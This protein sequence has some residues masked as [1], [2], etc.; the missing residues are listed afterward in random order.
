MQGLKWKRNSPWT[1]SAQARELTPHADV[2]PLGMGQCLTP[3]TIPGHKQK[4]CPKSHLD[5]WPHQQDRDHLQQ[6][7]CHNHGPQGWMQTQLAWGHQNWLALPQLLGQ[8]E[9]GQLNL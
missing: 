9:A 7:I 5:K 2:L 1:P 3:T 4:V 6:I 8:G